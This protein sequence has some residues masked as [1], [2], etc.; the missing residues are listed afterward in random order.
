MQLAVGTTILSAA[1]AVKAIPKSQVDG[2]SDLMAYAIFALS[3]VILVGI[4]GYWVSILVRKRRRVAASQLN[5]SSVCPEDM[6]ANTELVVALLRKAAPG[7]LLAYLDENS[8]HFDGDL[9]RFLTILQNPYETE[10]RAAAA[11]GNTYLALARGQRATVALIDDVER[12]CERVEELNHRVV[13]KDHVSVVAARTMIGGLLLLCAIGGLV[14][15]AVQ[16]L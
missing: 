1:S 2:N 3:G 13:T 16:V 7:N 15:G 12:L 8:T 6:A 4:L 11:D 9:Q 10:L 14:I 5:G